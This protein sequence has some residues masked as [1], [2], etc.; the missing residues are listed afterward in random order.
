[1]CA[2]LRREETA[3]FPYLCT[4]EADDPDVCG[5]APLTLQG[6]GAAQH[7]LGY[8]VGLGRVAAAARVVGLGT[9]GY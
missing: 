6:G 8:Q 3:A 5:T 7:Q 9:L 1:M 4:V 2:I